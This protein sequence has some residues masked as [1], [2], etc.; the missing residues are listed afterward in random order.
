MAIWSRG[1]LYYAELNCGMATKGDPNPIIS[2]FAQLFGEAETVGK[3]HGDAAPNAPEGA[4]NIDREPTLLERMKRQKKND[5]VRKL[6]FSRLR[7][8]IHADKGDMAPVPTTATGHS[9]LWSD[10]AAPRPTRPSSLDQV[11]GADVQLTTWWGNTT[12]AASTAPAALRT[13]HSELS[14]A[15]SS[16]ARL[17][18]ASAPAPRKPITR[19][20]TNPIEIGIRSAASDFAG[21]LFAEAQTT[22][23][24]LLGQD[25]LP[26][27]SAE[28]LTTCLLEIYRGTGQHEEF[29][30]LALQYAERFG[31]SPIE[32]FEVSRESGP[33]LANTAIANT[34]NSIWYCP[35]LLDDRALAQCIRVTSANNFSQDASGKMVCAIDWSDLKN[36]DPEIATSWAN[37][38]NSWSKRPIELHWSG[39]NELLDATERCKS[40]AST[41]RYMQWWLI[42]L[43]LL[44]LLQQPELHEAVALDYCVEFEVSA[45]SMHKVESQIILQ[46]ALTLPNVPV[47]SWP[48]LAN[49]KHGELEEYSVITLEGSVCSDQDIGAILNTKPTGVPLTVH[50]ARLLRIDDNRANKL[51]QWA[52]ECQGR[53]CT[54]HF[55]HLPKLGHALFHTLG[56]QKYATLTAAPR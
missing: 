5:A 15:D 37:Q 20:S 45:P 8:I 12:S 13:A 6:E 7:A 1:F 46:N 35:D 50:C 36:I 22:L 31:R 9:N 30:L 33:A 41:K 55:T 39:I 29:E 54:L 32:W 25:S 34:R 48:Q 49:D 52:K 38:I 17:D 47:A 16:F 43:E 23:S 24:N 3:D 27:S 11:K 26:E 4:P 10:R 53:Q 18:S 2:L 51:I 44:C 28:L 42:H 19:T 56:L 21:G 14:D 40:S